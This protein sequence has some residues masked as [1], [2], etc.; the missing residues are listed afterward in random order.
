M[1]FL[2]EIFSIPWTYRA[3]FFLFAKSYRQER[4]QVWKHSSVLY[5]IVDLT[6]SLTFALIEI[7]LV[8]GAVVTFFPLR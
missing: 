7:A 2:G 8:L 1:E 5:V 3:W 6:L 4:I